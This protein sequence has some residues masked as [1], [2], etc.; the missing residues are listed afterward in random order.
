M[1]RHPNGNGDTYVPWREGRRT[2]EEAEYAGEWSKPRW[3]AADRKGII[4]RRV[5][6][7]AGRHAATRVRGL[8][9]H[10]RYH[11]VGVQRLNRLTLRLQANEQ[12]HSPHDTWERENRWL[13]NAW[14]FR[15]AVWLQRVRATVSYRAVEA[16]AYSVL[17]LF[18]AWS[19]THAT[20]ASPIALEPT[21]V[22]RPAGKRFVI[23]TVVRG[24]GVEIADRNQANSA[25]S[26]LRTKG[27]SKMPCNERNQPE[28]T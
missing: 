27:L 14:E 23:A 2:Y 4:W 15:Q 19:R 3:V 20:S 11:G 22:R 8:R 1:T 18:F 6:R 21:D 10:L 25:E 7:V 17:G 26:D 28:G 9:R 13:P 12:Q 24:N 5:G 16:M